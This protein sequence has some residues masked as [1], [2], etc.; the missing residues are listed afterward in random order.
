MG[1]LHLDEDLDHSPML[2]KTAISNSLTRHVLMKNMDL[3]NDFDEQSMFRADSLSAHSAKNKR[4]RR[5]IEAPGTSPTHI[6]S[7]RKKKKATQ[8]LEDKLFA[9]IHKFTEEFP[10]GLDYFVDRVVKLY[11]SLTDSINKKAEQCLEDLTHLKYLGVQLK[12]TQ[13]KKKTCFQQNFLNK[14]TQKE[15]PEVASFFEFGPIKIDSILS[16]KAELKDRCVLDIHLSLVKFFSR[17]MHVLWRINSQ[18]KK[19]HQLSFST[20]E[21]TEFLTQ[22]ELNFEENQKTAWRKPLFIFKSATF[23]AKSLKTLEATRNSIAHNSSHMNRHSMNNFI[24][25]SQFSADDI[26]KQL[27]FEA[28]RIFLKVPVDDQNNRMIGRLNEDIQVFLA[29]Q[30]MADAFV[31]LFVNRYDFANSLFLVTMKHGYDKLVQE[32]FTDLRVAAMQR[33]FREFEIRTN[34]LN[35]IFEMIQRRSFEIR[36]SLEASNFQVR[37]PSI[38]QPLINYSTPQDLKQSVKPRDVKTVGFKDIKFE[39]SDEIELA[40]PTRLSFQRSPKSKVLFSGYLTDLES[41]TQ[42]VLAKKKSPSVFHRK[43]QSQADITSKPIASDDH[44]S[45]SEK[46]KIRLENERLLAEIGKRLQGFSRIGTQKSRIENVTNKLYNENEAN[47]T[48]LK[49]ILMSKSY[50]DQISSSSRPSPSELCRGEAKEQLRRRASRP[51]PRQ[52]LP[53]PEASTDAEILMEQNK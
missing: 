47:N 44:L 30:I 36:M 13:E 46:E 21:L 51:E 5:F 35:Q 45:F 34:G 49:G 27:S 33:F 11:H 3:L 16:N 18:M 1:R 14:I 39:T 7:F 25:M 2:K 48:E 17:L 50:L 42:I 40:K 12:E 38:L 15:S 10:R 24:D 37:S 43:T 23:R 19:S 6:L 31:S 26:K 20:D 28:I 4:S 22:I 53:A 41:V 29:R 32:L 52:K 9:E 8:N